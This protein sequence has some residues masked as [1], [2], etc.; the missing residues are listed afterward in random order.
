[1]ER[2][3]GGVRKLLRLA[4]LA[5]GKFDVPPARAVARGPAGFEAC[6]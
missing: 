1:M 3:N 6:A 2:S 4:G 5:R